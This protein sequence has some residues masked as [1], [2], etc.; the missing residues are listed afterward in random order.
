MFFPTFCNSLSWICN[1]LHVFIKLQAYLQHK[2][3]H[4]TCQ[5][6]KYKKPSVIDTGLTYKLEKNEIILVKQERG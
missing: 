6:K 2:Q 5:N 4:H 1:C 3:F